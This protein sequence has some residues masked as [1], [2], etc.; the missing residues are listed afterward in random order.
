M[1][2]LRFALYVHKKVLCEDDVFEGGYVNRRL[3]SETQKNDYV[4]RSE[5]YER[6]RT[7]ANLLSDIQRS[8]FILG[9]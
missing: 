8:L 4:L 7:R 6:E 3:I 1:N 9:G 2:A 5:M